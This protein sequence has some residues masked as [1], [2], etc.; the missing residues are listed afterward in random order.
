MR[1]ALK[2]FCMHE[3]TYLFRQFSQ[4]ATRALGVEVYAFVSKNPPALVPQVFQLCANLNAQ[5]INFMSPLLW[6]NLR[7]LFAEHPKK[8]ERDV[9]VSSKDGRSWGVGVR[10][11]LRQMLEMPLPLVI[12]SN[13]VFAQ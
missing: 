9:M 6:E 10:Q 1:N 5:Q 11:N 7:T 8:V 13:I 3:D 12:V 4:V 2:S